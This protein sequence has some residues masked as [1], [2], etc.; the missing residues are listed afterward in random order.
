MKNSLEQTLSGFGNFERISFSLPPVFSVL[1]NS[2]SVQVRFTNSKLK[3]S[4]LTG[5]QFQF[6]QPVVSY[7]D[8][9]N[10]LVSVSSVRRVLLS[11]VSEGTQTDYYQSNHPHYR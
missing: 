3:N 2:I 8:Q 1:K 4:Q 5:F 6:S 11:N 9:L 10:R 7:L